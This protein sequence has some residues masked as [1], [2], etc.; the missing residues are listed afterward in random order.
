MNYLPA[1]FLDEESSSKGRSSKFS[2]QI[3][4]RKVKALA[5][6]NKL[7]WDEKFDWKLSEN[8]KKTFVELKREYG[9]GKGKS[10]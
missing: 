8:E 1:D 6:S 5:N 2:S 4:A 10:L 9:N 7:V 3:H